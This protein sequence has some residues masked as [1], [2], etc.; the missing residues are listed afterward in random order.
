MRLSKGQKIIIW[1][2]VMLT[3]ILLGLDKVWWSGK[4]IMTER[5]TFYGIGILE[6]RLTME[7]SIRKKRD[8]V[9][10]RDNVLF[11][12]ESQKYLLITALMLIG[13]ALIITSKKK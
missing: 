11:W 8:L 2:V 3:V 4:G 1:T 12:I 13:G 9:V 6:P 7:V 10:I 5:L